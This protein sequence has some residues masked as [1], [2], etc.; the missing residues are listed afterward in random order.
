M[1][2]HAEMQATSQGGWRAPSRHEKHLLHAGG[3]SQCGKAV[4]LRRGLREK[5]GADARAVAMARLARPATHLIPHRLLGGATPSTKLHAFFAGLIW[6]GL[7]CC[8]PVRAE[9]ALVVDWLTFSAGADRNHF[10]LLDDRGLVLAQGEIVIASGVPG[11]RRQRRECLTKHSGYRHR[12]C[13]IVC[14]ERRPWRRPAC[15]SR[16]RLGWCN[17]NSS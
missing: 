16:R 11:R 12:A 17:I 4:G 8:M 13:W 5:G 14:L 1:K 10:S 9:T 2:T 7:A 3:V 15:E 6:L